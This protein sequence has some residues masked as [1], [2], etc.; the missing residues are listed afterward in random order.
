MSRDSEDSNGSIIFFWVFAAIQMVPLI[1][2]RGY[3]LQRLWGW[4]VIPLGAPSLALVNAVGLQ[5]LWTFLIA[6]L[7][8]DD[9]TEKLEKSPLTKKLTKLIGYWFIA[10]FILFEGWVLTH[11]MAP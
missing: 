9:E 8:N 7:R 10:G 1:L 11:W 4:F 5:V 2:F 3:V 6:S